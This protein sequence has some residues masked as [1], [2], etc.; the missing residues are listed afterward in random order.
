ML[1]SSMP[2]RVCGVCGQSFHARSDGAVRQALEEHKRSHAGVVARES[3]REEPA[4]LERVPTSSARVSLLAE[5]VAGF[6]SVTEMVRA[7]YSVNHD[8]LFVPFEAPRMIG[9]QVRVL[10]TVAGEGRF[11]L[12]GTVVAAFPDPVDPRPTASRR[13]NGV[14][15]T[16]A[17]PGWSRF[18]DG[19][20]A[21]FD[22]LTD[23]DRGPIRESV[24]G[25]VLE[26][27]DPTEFDDD[28]T[29]K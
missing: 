2:S 15:L 19:L 8:S 29:S 1:K 7:G 25:V 6:D 9:T 27:P 18:C 4:V 14:F 11:E 10:L 12:K 13:G 24:R 17:S 20:E 21:G 26:D 5:V 16:S 3:S 28:P 22:D 23:P